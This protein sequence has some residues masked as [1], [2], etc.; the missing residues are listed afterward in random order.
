MYITLIKK[1]ASREFDKI[2]SAPRKSTSLTS[3]SKT[4]LLGLSSS[5]RCIEL[6]SP[7]NF[8]IFR[9]IYIF[10]LFL[11]RIDVVN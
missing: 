8:N 10:Q 2:F 6:S 4:L 9:K 5:T 11:L 1:L 3:K 7:K